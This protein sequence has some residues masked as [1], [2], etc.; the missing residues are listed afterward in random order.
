MKRAGYL[1]RVS[2][3]NQKDEATIES[4]IAEIKERIKQD[5]NTLTEE[6]I[7]ID[8][9][10]TGEL[11]ARP[12]LDK[13]RDDAKNHKFDVLYVYDR[14]RIARLYYLQQVIIE[15]LF[16]LSI[17]FVTLHDVKAETPEEKVLQA[18]QGVFH[19]YEKV[20]ITERF[21]RGKLYKV[22][23][24]ELLGYNP[25]YGYDYIHK[26]KEKNG[27]F[28]INPAEAKIVKK[29]FY[30]VGI[31]MISLREV[32]RRLYELKIPPRKQKR[33]TWTKG[34]IARMLR[35]ETYI[36]NHYYLKTEAVVSR[37]SKCKNHYHRV[38]KNS[39][40][41]RPKEEWI[42]ISVPA[43][44]KDKELF[45]KVQQQLD[46]NKKFA[47]RNTK[48]EY[49]LQGLIYCP[50]GQKRT[51]EGIDGHLYYRC[52]DR[53]HRFPLP[54]Q[55]RRAGVN[56]KVAD[57]LVWNK[58]IAM[59]NSPRTIQKQ[60]ERWLRTQKLREQ[61]QGNVLDDIKNEKEK[62]REEEQR[63]SIAYGQGIMPLEVY[64]T[65]MAELAD[66]RKVL[67]LKKV[68]VKPQINL[69]NVISL[70]KLVRLAIEIIKTFDFSDKKHVIRQL[71][72]KI[73]ADK[74]LVVISGHIPITGMHMELCNGDRHC[75]FT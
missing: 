33:I 71:V 51:G 73:T 57:T 18:M 75:R 25:L 4:Q 14:G 12:E 53:L 59:L 9:G 30:W 67:E 10:Y 54:A 42:K 26:T 47:S 62:L 41:V 17:E 49:L 61:N 16:D 1:A 21:R 20:K 58:I 46:L 63:Y 56:A 60:A 55:C 64:Q 52:T 50:C 28:V 72:E 5:G 19:E 45:Y 7:Y 35:D 2:T 74:K 11:L 32:I 37:S 43:I 69:R 65:R 13:L 24:G 38:K 8:E 22:K 3:E 44:I 29:I 36:G 27:Y 48:R 39:R 23:K 66:K 15:E 68:E 31:E 6:C 70:K 34:P 40:R